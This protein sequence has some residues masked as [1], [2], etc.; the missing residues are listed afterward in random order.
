MTTGPNWYDVLDVDPTATTDEIRD[1][2]RASIADLTPADRRF[3]LYNQAAEVLLDPERRAAHDAELAREDHHDVLP[4]PAP[5][6]EPPAAAQ[7]R[8]RR[9]A[10]AGLP[11]ALGQ[12]VRSRREA[13]ATRP[14]GA[15]EGSARGWVAP[16]WLLVGLGLLTVLSLALTGYLWSQPSEAA[17]AESASSARNAAERAVV[18][19]LSYD[20]E[21][22]EEDQEAA[23]EV[24]TSDYRE[25]Y[26]ELF[27]VIEENAPSTR[28]VVDVDVLASSIVRA[29]ED[30]TEVLLFVD[31]PTTNKV[32]K[33]P[34]VYKDQVTVTMQRVDGEWLV[35]D[36]ETS[37]AQQ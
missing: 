34:V 1:S 7:R 6:G 20:Y 37:P 8:S 12:A 27:A 18:T 9:E 5:V 11:A 35:D 16:T 24:I 21:T 2:W 33:E 29:G 10:L 36:V 30:R 25:D 28:T 14:A 26:D 19:V 22:L 17:V 31:R 3:R 4:A 15:G 13:R 32:T 23:H